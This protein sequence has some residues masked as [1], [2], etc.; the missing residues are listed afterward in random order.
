MAPI[1]RS[2]HLKVSSL[3]EM[4]DFSVKLGVSQKNFTD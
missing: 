4:N 2:Q 3:E 1:E